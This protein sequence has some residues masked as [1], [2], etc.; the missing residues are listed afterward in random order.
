MAGKVIRRQLG[1]RSAFGSRGQRSTDAALAYQG[2]QLQREYD[3]Y[4]PRQPTIL[5][6]QVSLLGHITQGL[7]F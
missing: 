5:S 1:P 3:C 6:P 4:D 7:M 2:M